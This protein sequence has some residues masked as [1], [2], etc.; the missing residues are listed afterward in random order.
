MIA[1]WKFSEESSTTGSKQAWDKNYGSGYPS[2]PVCKDWLQKN[3]EPTFGYPD[4]VRFSWAPVKKI[5]AA[6]STEEKSDIRT[7]TFEADLDFDEDKNKETTMDINVKKR[8]REQM[9]AFLNINTTTANSKKQVTR[10]QLPYFQRRRIQPVT[11][12]L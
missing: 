3:I 4:I 7:V 6:G 1:N 8:Q 9:Y 12:L 11:K 2:D 5:L 10:N